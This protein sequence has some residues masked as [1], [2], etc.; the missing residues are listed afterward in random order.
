MV[1]ATYKSGRTDGRMWLNFSCPGCGRK[2]YGT[3]ISQ[4]ST[5]CS[6][7]GHCRS[8]QNIRNLLAYKYDRLSHHVGLTEAARDDIEDCEWRKHSK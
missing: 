6:T 4:T 8:P 3:F 2:L 7:D 1:V 5:V